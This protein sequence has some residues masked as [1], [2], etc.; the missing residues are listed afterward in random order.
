[1]QKLRHDDLA[2]LRSSQKQLLYTQNYFANALRN[3]II[4]F[5]RN[6]YF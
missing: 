6:F 5:L 4:D 3:E 1:M 2:P